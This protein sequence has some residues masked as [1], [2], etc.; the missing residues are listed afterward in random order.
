MLVPVKI[1]SQ[2]GKI[3]EGSFAFDRSYK[4]K[5][6]RQSVVAKLHRAAAGLVQ[7]AKDPLLLELF[8]D[9]EDDNY[10]W[11]KV[12]LF[13]RSEHFFFCCFFMGVGIILFTVF[14]NILAWSW[15]TFMAPQMGEITK[16]SFEAFG[17]QVMLMG[18]IK[19][20]TFLILW[21]IFYRKIYPLLMEIYGSIILLGEGMRKFHLFIISFPLN[22]L[23]RKPYRYPR[24]RISALQ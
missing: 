8:N 20:V 24:E 18:V 6:S 19:G 9:T 11:I 23:Q 16:N 13:S 12:D 22:I 15:F 10:D 14:Y 2:D 21:N 3:F 4:V 17:S 5:G 1:E 7:N